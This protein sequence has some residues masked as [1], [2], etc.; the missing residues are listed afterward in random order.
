M[1]E[2]L[3]I[4]ENF[5]QVEPG[6]N[7]PL[8]DNTTSLSSQSTRMIS[9]AVLYYRCLSQ[10]VS[11]IQ[12]YCFSEMSE[13]EVSGVSGIGRLPYYTGGF[14]RKVRNRVDHTRHRRKQGG[15]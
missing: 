10:L 11:S 8:M 6:N 7:L 9:L 12:K 1:D 15:I 2:E 5:A 13:S 3:I 14:L 4:P